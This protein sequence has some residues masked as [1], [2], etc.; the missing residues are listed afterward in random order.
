MGHG[1]VFV[2]LRVANS[3]RKTDFAYNNNLVEAFP[4]D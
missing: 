1:T 3:I 2:T 4:A